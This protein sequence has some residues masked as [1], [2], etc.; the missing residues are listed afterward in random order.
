MNYAE[1]VGRARRVNEERDVMDRNAGMAAP[2]D[3][4]VSAQLRTAI[5][6]IVSGIETSGVPRELAWDCIAEGLVILQDAELRVREM[7]L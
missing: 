7:G 1:L 3:C 6:A 4:P 2:G 5:Q